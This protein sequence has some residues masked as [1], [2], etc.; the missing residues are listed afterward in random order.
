MRSHG[1]S[2]SITNREYEVLGLLGQGMTNKQIGLR[3]GISQYTVRDHVST[4]LRKMEVSSRVELAIA[5]AKS[6]FIVSASNELP[7]PTY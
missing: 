6:T 5:S 4:L 2:L 7:E 1:G 3:L